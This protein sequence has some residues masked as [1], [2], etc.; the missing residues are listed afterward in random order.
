MSSSYIILAVIKATK[1]PRT[2]LYG[3]LLLAFLISPWVASAT[4]IRSN[5]GSDTI[6]DSTF[7]C[8]SSNCTGVGTSYGVYAFP[9]GKGLSGTLG[10]IQFWLG[11]NYASTTIPYKIY[12]QFMVSSSTANF[13]DFTFPN[14][15]SFAFSSYNANTLVT[16]SQGF[17]NLP[18]EANSSY[19]G[20]DFVFTEFYFV[21]ISMDINQVIVPPF[22]G[23]ANIPNYDPGFAYR[24]PT[25]LFYPNPSAETQKSIY[26][27][28]Y[29][30]T[31]PPFSGFTLP[32]SVLAGFSTT[33][34]A[35]LCDSSFATS[36]GFLDS[37][38]SSIS[39]GLC[40]VLSF[41]FVPNASTLDSFGNFT[42]SFQT[43]IPFSY[44][45]DVV[46]EFNSLSASSSINIPTYSIDLHSAGLGSTTAIGN[47]LP[48]S[49]DLLSSTTVN[50]YLPAGVH[51]ALFTLVRAAIFWMVGFY[52]YRRIRGMFEA[53]QITSI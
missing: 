17:L 39:N 4:S 18:I 27:S 52:F 11:P 16:D 46:N 49:M 41:L 32:S 53:T 7:F 26:F 28:V 8:G 31:V 45:Y 36:T 42:G 30:G 24:T 38:G 2:Y 35:T 34:V 48:T 10:G 12:L 13:G 9:L 23:S 14:S 43:K 21:Q 44:F 6:L 29:S 51:D 15:N 1:K 20:K 3:F 5:A 33:T 50:K 40:R 22:V 19:T 37:V 47:F 25:S